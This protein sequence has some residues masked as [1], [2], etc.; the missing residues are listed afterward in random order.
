MVI[1]GDLLAAARCR[2][3]MLLDLGFV[4]RLI[5][6]CVRVYQLGDLRIYRSGRRVTRRPSVLSLEMPST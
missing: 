1:H 2:V 4:S 5:G 6:C 3:A